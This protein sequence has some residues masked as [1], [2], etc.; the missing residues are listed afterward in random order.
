MISLQEKDMDSS[1]VDFQSIM[2][3]NSRLDSY[4][5]NRRGHEMS[6]Y[7]H[8]CHDGATPGDADTIDEEPAPLNLGE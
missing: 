8:Q 1:S 4:F 3:E 2:E 5:K 6:L 7:H